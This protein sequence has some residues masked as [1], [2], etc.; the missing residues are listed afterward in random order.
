M[1]N[2]GSH[3][4]QP[5]TTC[6][7]KVDCTAT[8]QRLPVSGRLTTVR[9]GH[10]QRPSGSTPQIKLK[11][12]RVESNDNLA[13]VRDIGAAK[14]VAAGTT[15][16][17]WTGLAET[18]SEGQVLG[19]FVDNTSDS[20]QLLM[21]SSS[22]G[23]GI[24]LW[25]GE[26]NTNTSDHSWPPPATWSGA[27]LNLSAVVRTPPVTTID[28]GPSGFTQDSSPSFAYSADESPVTFQCSLDGSAY[29]ACAA[30]GYQAPS[31]S[32]GAHSFSVRA[33]NDIGQT[34]PVATR[35][36]TVDRTPPDTSITSGP[37]GVET[38]DP[39]PLFTFASTEAGSFQCKLDDGAF[40]ACPSP[41][42][43]A[44]ELADGQH[45]LQVRAIDQAG[46]VDQT[47]AVATF[48]V[49]RPPPPAAAP[50][51]INFDGQSWTFSDAAD[52]L[53]G[54]AT[55]IESVRIVY[56]ANG[57][58]GALVR[59]YGSGAR[60]F[61]VEMHR[62]E[63]C[64]DYSKE[65]WVSH[66]RDDNTIWATAPMNGVQFVTSRSSA[67][68]R[69]VLVTIEDP[70]VAGLALRCLSVRSRAG[71]DT[72]DTLA[73]SLTKRTLVAYI[74]PRE[75]VMVVLRQSLTPATRML[76][77]QT[78]QQLARKR[79]HTVSLASP[80]PGSVGVEWTV[81]AAVARRYGVRVRRGAKSV[82]LA[83][84]ASR[85]AKAAKKVPVKVKVN[86]AGRKVL[87]KARALRMQ[88]H[89]GYLAQ[90]GSQLLSATK[91]VQ[92]RGK[93]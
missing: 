82:T 9:I 52:S 80:G 8:G 50:W 75:E 76:V 89:T 21:F 73:M 31:L 45:T 19:F 58:F 33:T 59:F 34:G 37:N 64:T 46:N 7:N 83:V 44:S 67:D 87:R 93:R 11:L 47:P 32:E 39:R 24:A 30:D 25:T 55:D 79:V 36:F 40:L 23:N 28:S 70:R 78:P 10:A 26:V 18:V 29:S 27:S 5:W 85:T 3:T 13:L 61:V 35:T 56:D 72:V 2:V 60:S 48:V 12:F 1:V 15:V 66:L 62:T 20:T 86:P 6:G 38:A 68:G 57:R 91:A 53:G 90:G 17:E 71:A 43:P 4:S 63:L 22:G 74:P 84:G 54:P 42:Q 16:T 88:V 77:R 41:S 69:E 14:E 49:R 65:L 92:L 81:S 51:G